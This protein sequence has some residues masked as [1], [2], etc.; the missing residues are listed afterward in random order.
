MHFTSTFDNDILLC[1]IAI[2][3]TRWILFLCYL[4]TARL[5]H[6]TSARWKLHPMDLSSRIYLLWRFGAILMLFLGITGFLNL[7]NLFTQCARQLS[8]AQGWYDC[9][10]HFQLSVIYCCGAISLCGFFSILF[11]FRKVIIEKFLALFG[12]AF[13]CGFVAIRAVSYH[14]VDSFLRQQWIGVDYGWIF[15]FAGI[16]CIAIAAIWN[17]KL[18]AASLQ[19]Q[20]IAQEDEAV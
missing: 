1:G 18:I 8:Q 11:L 6:W 5:C 12:M 20:L 17:V 4:F 7:Q 10:S 2:S 15:E 19:K 16:F 3:S 14:D 9:R 13:L